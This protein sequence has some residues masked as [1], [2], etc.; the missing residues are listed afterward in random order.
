MSIHRESQMLHHTGSH[1]CITNITNSNYQY[2][3]TSHKIFT[4]NTHARYSIYTTKFTLFAH[5]YTITHANF[6]NAQNPFIAHNTTHERS[7]FTKSLLSHTDD[8]TNH[9]SS[10]KIRYHTKKYSPWNAQQIIY[11]ALFS[12]TQSSHL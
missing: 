3:Y 1:K 9:H 12:G 7:Q 8:Y 11:T 4:L 5:K 10:H 2:S 6:H